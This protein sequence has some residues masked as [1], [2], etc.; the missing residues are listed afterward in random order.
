[1][2]LAQARPA[3]PPIQPYHPTTFLERGVAVPFT[4]PLLGGTRARLGE[5]PG[6][7][8]VVPNPSG[9]RGAYIM[10]WSGITAWCRPTLHDKVLNARIAALRGVT[11]E[12]IRRVAREIAIEGLAGEEAK[13]AAILANTTERDDRV[14]TNYRLLLALIEQVNVYPATASGAAAAD[15]L[16]RRAQLTAAWV[17]PRIGQPTEWVANALEE[18]AALMEGNGT[19]P[20]ATEGRMPRLLTLLRR[21]VHEIDDWSR[22]QKDEEAATHAAMLR[23]VAA[24]TLGLAEPVLLEAQNLTA[25][26][27]GL[28]RRWSA[29]PDPV[30]RISAR[31]EWLLDGWDQI[32]LVWAHADDD[33]E[34]RAALAEISGLLPILPREANDWCDAAQAEALT[35]RARRLVSLNEDWRTG[36]AVLDLIAR[37]EHFRALRC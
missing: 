26:M 27:I 22:V 18:L 8:L 29:D 35:M 24:F 23:D 34:R 20:N 31:P 28:L 14:V 37:N 19:G 11:P 10:P 1:M 21:V 2:S 4:T 16:Q 25:D 32:C 13:Q 33:I 36:A 7:E 6:A 5:K 17:A 15:D 3:L 30:I 12:T 9:G